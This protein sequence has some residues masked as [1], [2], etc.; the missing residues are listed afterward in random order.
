[1]SKLL[2]HGGGTRAYRAVGRN[3]YK[4]LGDNVVIENTHNRLFDLAH[5]IKPQILL[6][7]ISEYTQETHNFIGTKGKNILPVLYVDIE[8]SQTDLLSFLE[9]QTNAKFI[10]DNR[11]HTK[12]KNSISY[13]ILYD[14]SIFYT[15]NNIDRNGKIAVSLSSNNEINHK[16]L[17]NFI[18]PNK[19]DIPIVLFN[20]PEFKHPQNI[21]IFNEPDLNFILNTYSYFIDMDDEFSIESAVCRISVLDKDSLLNI[22]SVVHKHKAED[23]PNYKCSHIVSTRILPFLGINK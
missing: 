12:L 14:D 1:M 2:I 17:D 21:G 23:L 6:Y 8:V 22:K 9:N 10:I 13:D 19:Q 7:P 11:T 4:A 16:Y 18:F 15:L 5:I 3:L 20:N